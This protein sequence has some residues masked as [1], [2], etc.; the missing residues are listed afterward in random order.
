MMITLI[1]FTFFVVTCP[2][3]DLMVCR[4]E[5]IVNFNSLLFSTPY[6]LSSSCPMYE[7]AE[8]EVKT[9]KGSNNQL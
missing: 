1:G 6:L 9:Q 7:E 8:D 3:N 2:F 4:I 5:R